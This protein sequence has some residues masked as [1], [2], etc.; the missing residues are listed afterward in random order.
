MSWMLWVV[1]AWMLYSMF[2]VV[3]AVGK[4]REPVTPKLAVASAVISL[5]MVVLIVLGGHSNV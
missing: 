2:A 4:E 3:G 5:A 1:V